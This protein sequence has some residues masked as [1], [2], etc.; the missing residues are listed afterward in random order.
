MTFSSEARKGKVLKNCL[1]FSMQLHLN[2][3]LWTKHPKYHT[4]FAL[5]SESSKTT[6]TLYDNHECL[7]KLIQITVIEKYLLLFFTEERKSVWN[8]M[9]VSKR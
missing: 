9:G 4:T 5:C 8:D 7:N 3:W 6:I 2:F 1:V